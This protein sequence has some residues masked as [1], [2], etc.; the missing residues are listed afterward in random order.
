MYRK[1]RL[2]V[3]RKNEFRKKRTAKR[4][5]TMKVTRSFPIS[6]PLDLVSVL[7]VSIPKQVM[8][9]VSSLNDVRHKLQ[10]IPILPAGYH[11]FIV[12]K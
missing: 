12:D 9:L 10:I 8:L 6:L 4:G 7:K 1:L 3:H 2:S 11:L 5:C